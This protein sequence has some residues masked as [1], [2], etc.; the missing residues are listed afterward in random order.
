MEK[1]I[2]T[3]KTQARWIAWGLGINILLNLTKI[4]IQ[5]YIPHGLPA[6]PAPA[7]ALPSQ[8]QS[9]TIGATGLP[10]VSQRTYYTTEEVAELE[11]LSPRTILTYIAQDR[12]T[13]TPYR[14]DRHWQISK[15][16]QIQ[17]QPL[18]TNNAP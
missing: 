3:L 12:I 16:Y 17:S 7:P 1:D 18:A 4:A 13:P 10:N 5:L 14:T 8:N 15:D 2:A 6:A 9:V 11:G